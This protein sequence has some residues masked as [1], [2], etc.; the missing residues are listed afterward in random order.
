MRS[1]VL[2]MGIVNCE[3]L[4]VNG[5]RA[6]LTGQSNFRLKRVRCLPYSQKI[7]L[8]YLRI[9]LFF[10]QSDVQTITTRKPNIGTN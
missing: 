9:R 10:L 6:T 7:T 2:V 5:E 3:R 8:S 1:R 4:I